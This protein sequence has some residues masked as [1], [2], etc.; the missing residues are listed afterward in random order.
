[1]FIELGERCGDPD[2]TS[3]NCSG[4]HVSGLLTNFRTVDV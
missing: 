2:N 1:M 4:D 3:A